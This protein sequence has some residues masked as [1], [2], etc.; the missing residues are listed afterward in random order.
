MNF[1]IL[2]DE[3]T[4]EWIE[5]AS[6]LNAYDYRLLKTAKFVKENFSQEAS[7]YYKLMFYHQKLYQLKQ[8]YDKVKNDKDDAIKN[9][10]K[11]DLIKLKC[12]ELTY[13]EYRNKWY[14]YRNNLNDYIE[15]INKYLKKY[16]GLNKKYL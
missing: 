15:E 2:E 16:L 13:K 11:F 3:M 4:R 10:Y 14:F 7:D 12:N 9:E 8:W 6:C 1:W 5:K